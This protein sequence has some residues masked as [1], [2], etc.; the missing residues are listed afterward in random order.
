[1][2]RSRGATATPSPVL[3]AASSRSE[4]SS[5]KSKSASKE[6]PITDNQS[7]GGEGL[8]IAAVPE[9]KSIVDIEISEMRAKLPPID[10]TALSTWKKSQIHDE[11]VCTCKLIEVTPEDNQ[12]ES[13]LDSASVPKMSTDCNAIPEVASFDGQSQNRVAI[14]LP[15]T[16]TTV[17]NNNNSK[18]KLMQS[19]SENVAPDLMKPPAKKPAVKSIFDLDFDV[20][21]DD[22]PITFKLNHNNN[23][24]LNTK[25]NILSSSSRNNSNN[26][27]SDDKSCDE[28]L[29]L[30]EKIKNVDGERRRGGDVDEVGQGNVATSTAKSSVPLSDSKVSL[31][32]SDDDDDGGDNDDGDSKNVDGNGGA[33]VIA[34][35]SAN[36]I[37]I[38]SLHEEPKALSA[39]LDL[40]A[41]A[42]QSRF[43]IE[44][45]PD[46]K[47]KHLYITSKQSITEF[48][49]EKLHIAYIPNI[50]G[51]WN[52]EKCDED[53]SIP[54][55]KANEDAIVD[56]ENV[57]NEEGTTTIPAI[58]LTSLDETNASDEI[59]G[60]EELH[61]VENE[62]RVTEATVGLYERVVPLCNHLQMDRLPK[63][64]SHINL[65]FG[66]SDEVEPDVFIASIRVKPEVSETTEQMPS[67][68][69]SNEFKITTENIMEQSDAIDADSP[70]RADANDD[71]PIYHCDNDINDI[72]YRR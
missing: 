56:G 62:P 68:T 30:N 49:I 16:N 45:D 70:D 55:I 67:S 24:N 9:P 46:C 44:E 40:N 32:S 60:E 19:A 13:N 23:I 21:D 59:I 20:D 27:I 53:S 69:P 15:T 42:L 11:I 17:A 65:D 33:N 66:S 47:A 64:L 43:R 28:L 41:L 10:K 3:P 63:N 51:N 72:E 1:M 5:K 36:L 37:S 54:A 25:E 26:D 34:A 18:S 48:H 6:E 2:N 7:L 38:N 57:E 12:N 39:T 4:R 52:E 14:T 58:D 71:F 50:N 35:D 61:D 22:D 8:T 29:F 31:M